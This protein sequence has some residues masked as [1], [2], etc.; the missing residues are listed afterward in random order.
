M[1][2]VKDFAYNADDDR[3]RGVHGSTLNCIK[4]MLYDF[5]PEN[6]SELGVKHG[7]LVFIVSEFTEGWVVARRFKYF[8]KESYELESVEG[9][10]PFTYIDWEWSI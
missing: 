7:E 10:I 3:Y 4:C 8:S 5:E 2:N 1:L 6:D 9:I